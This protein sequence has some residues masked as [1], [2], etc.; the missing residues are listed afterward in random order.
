LMASLKDSHRGVRREAAEALHH[1]GAAAAP[2]LIEALGDPD[3]RIRA[4]AASAVSVVATTE[5]RAPSADELASAA[6]ALEN[7]LQDEDAE[8]RKN[9]AN[10]LDYIHRAAA[11]EKFFEGK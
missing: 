5:R 7:V 3:P 10:S 6:S 8:V 9:A 11:G 1:I 4:E 2:T